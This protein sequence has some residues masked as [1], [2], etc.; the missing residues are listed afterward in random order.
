[1]TA[2]DP[3][4]W[5]WPEACAMIERAEQLRRQFFQ[6]GFAALPRV[7]WEPPVDVFAS[8]RELLIVVALPG[9]DSQEIEISS[10]PGGLLVAGVRRLPAAAL[11][12]E[13]QRL[14]IPHG[15]F[16]RRIKLPA[17]GWELNR[18]VLVNGCLLVNL[19]KQA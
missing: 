6:P 13:I 3:R 2:A 9:V 15:R 17:T 19:R 8:E 14:E 7:N 12:M 4:S 11:G 5:M 18:S 10:E 1:M 16:E